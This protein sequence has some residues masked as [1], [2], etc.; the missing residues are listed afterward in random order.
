LSH[1]TDVVIYSAATLPPLLLEAGFGVYPAEAC[2]YAIEVKSTLTADQLRDAIGK[3]RALRQ[4]RYLPS[5]AGAAREV[6]RTRQRD[7]HQSRHSSHLRGRS[8]VL[9]VQ[10]L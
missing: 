2:I 7:R 4:L 6:S 9:V 5:A 8:R 10:S 3:H 1:E